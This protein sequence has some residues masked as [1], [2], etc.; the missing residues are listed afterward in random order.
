M[1]DDNR[2]ETLDFS[3]VLDSPRQR[4]RYRVVTRGLSLYLD[5]LAQTFDIH[6]LSSNGCN[7]HAPAELFA[8]GRI[9]YGDLH[10]GK[11][12]YLAQLTIKVVRHIA[13][14]NVACSFQALN[15]QQEFMLDKLL[16][17]IQKRNIVNHTA[18]RKREKDRWQHILP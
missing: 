2:H 18:R 4:G 6:D 3:I 17:E 15:R 1:M 11:T 13:D 8:T 7:L 14:H 10:I 5:A 12:N 9:F 16:L